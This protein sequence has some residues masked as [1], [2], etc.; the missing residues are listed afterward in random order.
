MVLM[1]NLKLLQIL[2]GVTLVVGLLNLYGTFNIQGQLQGGVAVPSA[3]APSPSAAPTPAAKVDVS[4]DDDPVKGDP[5]APITIIEFSDFECPF[6]GRFY[7]QTMGQLEEKYIKTGKAKIVFRDFPLSF[8]PKAQKASEASECADD[9]GKFWEMH[10]MIFENQNS[11]SVS[12]LK[13]YAG[14][15]G[16]D[17]SKFDSCLDS[18]EHEAEVQADFRDGSAAG[19]SGT[20]S[21]FVNGI[22]LVGAQPFQA[23]EQI[24]EA[25]L[26]S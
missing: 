8:H 9:Q 12:D 2:I 17:Q 22:K 26:N 20:P 6:C 16:L 21:F 4:V 25:E 10:D 5:D 19:V 3:A 15:L 14:Q 13:G 23:F 1:Q 18:G 11:I 24:I 7:S